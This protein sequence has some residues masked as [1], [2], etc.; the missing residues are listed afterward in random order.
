MEKEKNRA[1]KKKKGE[2][3]SS[4]D[5]FVQLICGTGKKRKKAKKKR[6]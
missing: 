5:S 2:K 3:N 1:R 4:I 6:K